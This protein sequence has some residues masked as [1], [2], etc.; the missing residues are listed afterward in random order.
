MHLDQC[1]KTKLVIELGE[2]ETEKGAEEA[3]VIFT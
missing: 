2:L 1:R 3:V